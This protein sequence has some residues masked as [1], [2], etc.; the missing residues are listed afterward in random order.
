MHANGSIISGAFR[1]IYQL[2]R[3][4]NANQTDGTCAILRIREGRRD[5]GNAGPGFGAFNELQSVAWKLSLWY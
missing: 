5:S 3:I 1:T 4:C 2:V